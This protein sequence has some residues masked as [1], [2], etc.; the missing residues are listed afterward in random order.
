MLNDAETKDLLNRRFDLLILDGAYPE[1]VLGMAYR[2]GVP[3]MYINTVGFYTG[4]M[5]IAGNPAPFSVTPSLATPYTDDMTLYQRSVNTALSVMMNV[6]HGVSYFITSQ[7]SATP[8]ITRS[9]RIFISL[10]GER[11]IP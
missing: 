7:L 6:L 2:Y 5:S 10:E 4:S 3:F 1:C 9:I 8:Q 11:G